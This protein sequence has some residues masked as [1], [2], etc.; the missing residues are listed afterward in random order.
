MELST[1][2]QI[3]ILILQTL[4][5]FTVLITVYFLVT[6]LR[7]QNKVARANARQNI[8]DSHQRLALAGLQKEL[9]TIKVKLRNNEPLTD[10]EESMYIT[11]FSAI[12]RA[13]ENQFYQNS[14]GMLDGEEW[15]SMVSSLKTLFNDE[16]NIEVWSFM[17]PTFAKNF[18]DFVDEKIKEREVYSKKKNS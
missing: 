18:V 1:S 2:T 8:A 6:E 12:V 3:M 15:S 5:P 7:E 17:A 9:V 13:R 11:H 14:I 10:E 16:K 4:G